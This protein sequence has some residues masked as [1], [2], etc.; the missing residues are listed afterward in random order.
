[1]S[2]TTVSFFRFFF[3]FALF[4]PNHTFEVQEKTKRETTE[5][6]VV[7]KVVEESDLE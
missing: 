5:E 4:L 2:T 1:L 7:V 6:I 3:S